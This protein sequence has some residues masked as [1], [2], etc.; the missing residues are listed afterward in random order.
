[1]VRRGACRPHRLRACGPT[2]SA[3]QAQIEAG[4]I[5]QHDGVRL[6]LLNFSER[7]AKLFSKET[8]VLNDFP[9][10]DNGGVID[11]V[12]EWLAG[13]RFHLRAAASEEIEI[14]IALA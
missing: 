5:D 9:Q 3:R 11:P 14:G 2:Q 4:V 12:H 13:D 8:V 6:A 10:T 1:M 7:F